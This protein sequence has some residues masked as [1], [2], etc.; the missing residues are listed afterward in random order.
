[1]NL[2]T[3]YMKEGRDPTW[4]ELFFD[5]AY[6]V[7]LGRLAHLLFHTHHEHIVMED[8]IGFVWIFAIGFLVWML[9]TVY[10]NIY[11]NGSMRQNIYG[12]ILMT[13]LFAV[14][15]LMVDIIENAR[16][17][18]TIMGGM[19]LVIALLYS[20]SLDAV[21]ENR[22]YAQ[23]KLKALTILGIISIS[24]LFLSQ[25]AAMIVIMIIYVG[26]HF[27]DELFLKRFGMAKPDGEHFVERIGIF[28]IL[29]SGESFITLVGNVPEEL[30]VQ[31]LL[32]VGFLLIVIF[33]MFINY[34][35]HNEQMAKAD[36]RRYSQLLLY[37]SFVMI[38]FALM[39]AIVY[40]G[41]HQE[42]N[43]DSFKVLIV[44]FL[45]LFYFGN[46]LS[47][48][49][50]P[51]QSRWQTLAYSIGFPVIFSG[52]IWVTGTNMLSLLVLTSIVLITGVLVTLFNHRQEAENGKIEISY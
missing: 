39:P 10:M 40:H 18:A 38:A 14:T 23:Y 13:C 30:T 16:Y 4:I 19:S 36:Y 9:Y 31:N 7:M 35:S 28:I 41:I 27:I 45:V 51:S 22:K 44:L 47:Y 33:A 1:M 12:F 25:D 34:F 20:R 37:N 32:P 2:I 52:V 26:E 11:G 48:R 43:H 17:I 21:E 8:I 50:V 6:A 46:G 42:L 15:I 49:M 24:T 29:L 5:L 3:N